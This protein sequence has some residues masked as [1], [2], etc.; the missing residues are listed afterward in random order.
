[1]SVKILKKENSKENTW[2]FVDAI[3]HRLEAAPSHERLLLSLDG[4]AKNELGLD[5]VA[6][7]WR[8][9]GRRSFQHL[10][11]N[12]PLP[13]DPAG[14]PGHIGIAPA[15]GMS[16]GKISLD[17]A[18]YETL[19]F[20][21]ATELEIYFVYSSTNTVSSRKVGLALRLWTYHFEKSLD[22]QEKLATAF[23]LAR[24]RS[25]T[26]ELGKGM[27]Y[28]PL[29]SRILKMTLSLV[30][31]DHGFIM[32]IDEET[33]LLKTE[34]EY[35]Q[36][37]TATPSVGQD[38]QTRVMQSRQPVMIEKITDPMGT[39]E[40]Q[41]AHSVICV[42][43]IKQ[44]QAF[45]VIYA[46]NKR[47]AVR[48]TPQDLD[49]V[50]ILASNVAAVVDQVR[51]FHK[52]ITDYL[53]GLYLR[54]H[55]EPKLEHEIRRSIR[56]G[57][58][59]SVITFDADHFKIVND[60]YGHL[61]G[62]AVLKA[63]ANVIRS[64]IRTGID[65]PVRMG[66]EEFA[67]LLPETPEA[68]ALC[69]AERIR[70]QMEQT[71]LQISGHTITITLS[72]GVATCPFHSET[73]ETLVGCADRALYHSKEQGRNRVTSFA[74]LLKNENAKNGPVENETLQVAPR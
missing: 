9:P 21:T 61:I 16:G 18:D 52:S 4:L 68:G 50:C 62:D 15:L 37:F 6:L 46:V 69:L 27:D 30:D 66:G 2:E 45:G 22:E 48:F 55:F 17:G 14:I 20:K 41:S 1:M 59:L 23:Q 71:S 24:I 29:L 64:N 28:K 57:T 5:R 44:D 32:I 19:H 65:L 3:L 31:A 26:E 74:T 56:Y 25:V 73:P 58:P 54:R 60:T 51:L 34:A 8:G 63:I 13:L 49:L 10:S 70:R 7:C 40:E 11:P 72:A 53:T 36:A 33:G 35:G 43:L 12:P 39:S 47:D 67:V 38:I 42:P